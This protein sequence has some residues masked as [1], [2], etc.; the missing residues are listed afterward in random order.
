MFQRRVGL[1]LQDGQEV[2]AVQGPRSRRRQR[3]GGGRARA[4]IEQ[5]HLA[6]KLARLE[7]VEH[8]L[9]GLLVG[10]G[11]LDLAAVED[12]EHAAVITFAEDGAAGGEVI[13][14]HEGGQGGAFVRV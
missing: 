8:D 12:V 10:D 7:H 14:A 5:R 6:K 1:P 2:L 9:L 3:P 13:L 4:P 11:Q